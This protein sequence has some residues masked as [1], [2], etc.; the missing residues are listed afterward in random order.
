MLMATKF[1]QNNVLIKPFNLPY[2]FGI[3]I[4]NSD[5]F[6]GIYIYILSVLLACFQFFDYIE[7]LSK[8]FKFLWGF[9]VLK[10]LNFL[11]CISVW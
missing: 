9:K 2:W 4:V 10:S 8:I 6:F 1:L 11:T 5:S 7:V 3:G